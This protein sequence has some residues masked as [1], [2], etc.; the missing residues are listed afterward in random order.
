MIATIKQFKNLIMLVFAIILVFTVF[1]NT[2]IIPT[3]YT[4]VLVRFGQIDDRPVQSGGFHFTTPLIEH[5]CRVNNKQQ[6]FHVRILFRAFRVLGKVGFGI[7]FVRVR[8]GI[9]G[10]DGIAAVLGRH[11]PEGVIDAAQTVPG[12]IFHLILA[13]GIYVPIGIIHGQTAFIFRHG[14]QAA[15]QQGCGQQQRKQD[16]GH[17]W[18]HG[19]VLLSG[20]GCFRLLGYTVS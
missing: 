12:Q 8:P 20:L 3:G 11:F 4:G 16:P 15:G 17:L 1:M 19:S 2:H 10:Y 13:V 14:R 9:G 18:V 5:I 7:V 6:D